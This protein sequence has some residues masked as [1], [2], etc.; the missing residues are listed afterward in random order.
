MSTLLAITSVTLLLL[1][2]RAALPQPGH[3]HLSHRVMSS[4]PPWL[5]YPITV[6]AFY[7]TILATRAYCLLATC[8][9]CLN[10]RIR[11]HCRITPAIVLGVAPVF[12]SHVEALHQAE[13][14]RSVIN[15]CREWNPHGALYAARRMRQLYLPTTDFEPPTLAMTL[16]AVA[17][18]DEAAAR[19]E[20]VYVHCKAG[21]GRSLCIVMAYL[22]LR[23]GL[24]PQ[25]AEEA[26]AAKRCNVARGK[27]ELPLF[28]ELVLLREAGGGVAGSSSSSSSSELAPVALPAA[29]SPSGAAAVAPLPPS[30]TLRSG[31]S[32]PP[33]S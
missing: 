29:A 1:L 10:Q 22:V 23:Q 13:N 16:A 8:L 19:G 11:L 15:L 24:S 21:R 26:V 12:A 7:P 3:M 28:K 30:L 18:I 4:L 17:F 9:P 31:A 33:K 20:S 5:K 2:L 14:V 27:W 6:L 25:E 32:S